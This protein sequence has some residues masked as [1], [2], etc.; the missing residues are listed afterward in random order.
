MDDPLRWRAPSPRRDP[1]REIALQRYIRDLERQLDEERRP[2]IVPAFALAAAF[3][4]ACGM[5]F[6]AA[7]L[8]MQW[9]GWLS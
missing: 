2:S 8:V 9:L 5:S 1:A 6:A 7:E 3:G 4:V